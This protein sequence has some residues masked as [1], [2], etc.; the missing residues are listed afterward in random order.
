VSEHVVGVEVEVEIGG[1]EVGTDDVLTLVGVVVAVAV[2]TTV[3]VGVV[4]HVSKYLS[5][6][7]CWDEEELVS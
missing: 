6:R 3:G 5:T 2:R 7:V 1:V 4:G